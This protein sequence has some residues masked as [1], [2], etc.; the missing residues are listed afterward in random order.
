MMPTF[1]SSYPMMNLGS[2]SACISVAAIVPCFNEA[3]AIGRVVANLKAVLPDAVIHVFDNNSSDGT[4]IVAQKLGAFVRHVS[5]QGKGNVVRRMFA[6]VEADVYVMVDGDATYDVSCMREHVALLLNQKLDMVVGSRQEDPAGSQIY[7]SGHRW[8]NRALTSAVAH[9]FGGEFT[10]MLSGYRVFSRRYVKT[11]PATSRGFEVE[12]ALTVHALE[13]RMPCAEVPVAYRS[14]MQG[15]VSKLS[16]FG[17]GW[18]ILLTIFKLFVSERPLSFFAITAAALAT[19]SLWLVVPLA[20][21]YL[22]TGLVLRLPT[23]VLATGTML[24][25]MLSLVCG[26]VL[27]TV[28]LGRREAQHVAYLSVG[29]PGGSA[30]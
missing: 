2:N 10:D 26:A 5:L 9:I 14:R 19:L 11:F 28:N 13:H 27:R 8:G 15:S 1:T 6:D 16:T 29:A 23:A 20:L 12:T 18:R 17:D 4:A 25:A 22:E 30:S 24:S 3:L 21:T 7:R